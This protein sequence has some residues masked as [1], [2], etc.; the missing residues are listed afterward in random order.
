MASVSESDNIESGTIDYSEL[1]SHASRKLKK[2]DFE[3]FDEDYS[4]EQIKYASKVVEAEYLHEHHPDETGNQR[5][6]SKLGTE[7][8][9]RILEGAKTELD[10]G[11]YNLGKAYLLKEGSEKIEDCKVDFMEKTKMTRYIGDS[12]PHDWFKQ[13]LY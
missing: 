5:L 7:D 2:I 13:D 12:N 3:H 9:E 1:V 6:L 4:I 8:F 10:V 11:L